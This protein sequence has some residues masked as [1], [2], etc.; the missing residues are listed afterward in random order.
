MT[1]RSTVR[2]VVAISVFVLTVNAFGQTTPNKP[3]KFLSHDTT[4]SAKSIAKIDIGADGQIHVIDSGGREFVAPKE[5]DQVSVAAPLLAENRLAAGWLVESGNCCT[6]YPIALMLVIYR[7]GKLLQRLGNGMMICDWNF[8]AGGKQVAFSTNTVHGDLAPH[9]ELRDT[10]TGRL[11]AKWDGP[12]NRKSP[13]WAA[14]L[15]S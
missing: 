2:I 14:R 11:I 5:K 1:T 7:P 15:R 8:E 6:S 13:T 12:L 10:Q 9:Y 4:S 3:A